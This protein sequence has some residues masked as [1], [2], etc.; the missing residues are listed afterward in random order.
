[1]QVHPLNAVLVALGA[2]LVIEGV[3]VIAS[4]SPGGII[5]DGIAILMIGGWNI[6]I[7][8]MEA[9]AGGGSPGFFMYFGVFQIIAG[10]KRLADFRHFTNLPEKPGDEAVSRLNEMVKN[11]LKARPKSDM[12]IIEFAAK[13]KSVQVSWRGKM[14]DDAA[15]FIRKAARQDIAL[16]E[17]EEVNIIRQKGP[18]VRKKIPITCQVG[19]DMMYGTIAPEHFARYESWKRK[20]TGSEAG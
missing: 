2:F 13:E 9:T 3:L 20:G 14:L 6:A 1:M 19:K 7:S 12:S 16:A 15:I 8:A 18:P 17:K 4:P 5:I 10:V 11:V